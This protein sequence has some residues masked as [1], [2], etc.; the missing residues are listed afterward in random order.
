MEKQ[1]KK[2]LLIVREEFINEMAE[3]INQSTLPLIIIEPILEKFLNSAKTGL[4][5][6]YENEINEYE[7]SLKDEESEIENIENITK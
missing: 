1:I 3:L 4:R 6:Q 5:E 2:T 7:Q